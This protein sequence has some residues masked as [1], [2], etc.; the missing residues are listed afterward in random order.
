ME[1]CKICKT[2]GQFFELLYIF[3][4]TLMVVYILLDVST[5]KEEPLQ[6][7]IHLVH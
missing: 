5:Q 3:D 7:K 6:Y 2:L 4:G 1:I